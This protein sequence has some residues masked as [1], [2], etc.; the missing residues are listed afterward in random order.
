MPTT[1]DVGLVDDWHTFLGRQGLIMR[2][3]VLWILLWMEQLFYHK[4]NHWITIGLS[5]RSVQVCS[6]PIHLNQMYWNRET[7]CTWDSSNI[8]WPHLHVS[9]KLNRCLREQ[10]CQNQHGNFF[11]DLRN[12]IVPPLSLLLLQLDG[13]SSDWTPLD[14]LHQ[15]RNIP[16]ETIDV[17]TFDHLMLSGPQ[18]WSITEQ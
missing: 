6:W 3:T 5:S 13:D 11:T 18:V 10:V 2:S 1:L 17:N 16:A 14:P 7:S 9:R 4:K 8:C 12:V 15:V